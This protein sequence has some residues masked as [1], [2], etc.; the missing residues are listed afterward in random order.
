MR[1]CSCPL[2]PSS[3]ASSSAR[4]TPARVPQRL[5]R[6]LA[7]GQPALRVPSSR[8]R[9]TSL[10]HSC[11]TSSTTSHAP[12]KRPGI[13]TPG[14]GTAGTQRIS[15]ESGVINTR[16]T[17][18][19]RDMAYGIPLRRR[20]R[21]L[22]RPRLSLPEPPDAVICAKRA[23]RPGLQQPSRHEHSSA[24]RSLFRIRDDEVGTPLTAAHAH[25]VTSAVVASAVPGAANLPKMED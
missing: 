1:W 10:P 3:L 20:G 25:A 8:T 11:N 21:Y 24:S 14:F 4:S 23:R 18:G 5:R 12:G 16:Q 9:C 15:D 13:L 7:L 17:F 19:S 22:T 6:D 2:L